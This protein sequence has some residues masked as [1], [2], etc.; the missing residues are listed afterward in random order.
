VMRHAE[1]RSDNGRFGG[2][3]KTLPVVIPGTISDSD[4]EGKRIVQP[5]Y[6]HRV[7]GAA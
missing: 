6:S 1:Q 7:T 5:I 2:C 3:P 4:V